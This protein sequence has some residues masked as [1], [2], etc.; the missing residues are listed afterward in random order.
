MASAT[1]YGNVRKALLN[2]KKTILQ[3]CH[4]SDVYYP[5]ENIETP[6]KLDF[7]SAPLSSYACAD[8]IKGRS[9]ILD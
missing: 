9:Q 7:I 3:Y 1:N 2:I 5:G 6:D 4:I 8:Y